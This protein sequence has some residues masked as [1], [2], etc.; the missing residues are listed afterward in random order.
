[1]HGVPTLRI[2]PFLREGW[3]L[4]FDQAKNVLTQISVRTDQQILLRILLLYFLTELGLMS[5]RVEACLSVQKWYSKNA[6]N[7]MFNLQRSRLLLISLLLFFS[8]FQVI[9]SDRE[10]AS[11]HLERLVNCNVAIP[12]AWH[13]TLLSKSQI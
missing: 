13:S 1:M 6:M 5:V 8:F 2:T 10:D 7:N 4:S 12:A 3:H 9:L 11:P